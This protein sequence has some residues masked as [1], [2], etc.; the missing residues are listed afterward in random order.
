[1]IVQR[2]INEESVDNQIDEK[3]LAL[4]FIQEA[5]EDGNQYARKDATWEIVEEFPEAPNN[6]DLHA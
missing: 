6:T 5:P 2:N 4:G 3:L 1:M